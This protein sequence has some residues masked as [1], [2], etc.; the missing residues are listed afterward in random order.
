VCP[1][2]EYRASYSKRKDRDVT[3]REYGDD[4]CRCEALDATTEGGGTDPRS[5]PV[6]AY[7]AG[8]R[9]ERRVYL[10]ERAMLEARS[11]EL[12]GLLAALLPM[13]SGSCCTF[14][15]ETKKV[16]VTEA[17]CR[18]TTAQMRARRALLGGN[19]VE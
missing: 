8:R 11:A 6:H 14:H 9:H 15:P 12:R 10:E 18:C 7:E 3:T 1:K 16:I 2:S 5:C 13:H 4:G 17:S 19:W